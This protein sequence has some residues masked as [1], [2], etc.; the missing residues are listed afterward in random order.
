MLWK[1]QVVYSKRKQ[2]G[3]ILNLMARKHLKMGGGR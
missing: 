3:T 2:L 1:E